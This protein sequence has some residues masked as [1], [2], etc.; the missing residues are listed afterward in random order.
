MYREDYALINQ[1]SKKQNKI[2]TLSHDHDILLWKKIPLILIE[3]NSDINEKVEEYYEKVVKDKDF[4][5]LSES[6]ID[7]FKTSPVNEFIYKNSDSILLKIQISD[8]IYIQFAEKE[9]GTSI[10][11]RLDIDEEGISVGIEKTLEDN[12]TKEQ[13]H[14]VSDFIR[15]YTILVGLTFF[16]LNKTDLHPIEKVTP[17]Y[18]KIMKRGKIKKKKNYEHRTIIYLNKLPVKYNNES[19]GGHHASPKRH[20]RKGHT[21]TLRAE[22]FKHHPDYMKKKWIKPMWIGK[23]ETII[24]GITYKVI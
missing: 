11:S 6:V 20:I 16:E 7:G 9:L 17:V 14:Q 4:K 22:K 3:E 18:K 21:R 10:L 13:I 2:D 5:E 19:K 8:Y 1:I 12:I 24:D 15:H 23:K